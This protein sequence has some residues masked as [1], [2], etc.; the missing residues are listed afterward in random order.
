MKNEVEN[1]GANPG[2]VRGSVVPKD[3]RATFRQGVGGSR[4]GPLSRWAQPQFSEGKI[5]VGRIRELGVLRCVTGSIHRWASVG[6]VGWVSFCGCEG[7][8]TSP[9]RGEA[10]NGSGGSTSSEPG[11]DGTDGFGLTETTVSTSQSSEP[12]AGNGATPVTSHE[13]SGGHD[14]P[15][16]SGDEPASQSEST[17]TPVSVSSTS[18]STAPDE[19]A[20][21]VP[22]ATS[23]SGSVPLDADTSDDG[24][25]GHDYILCESFENA[26]NGEI[27]AGWERRGDEVFVSDESVHRGSKALK[28]D[29]KVSWERRIVHDASGLGAAHWGRI[30]YRVEL[31]VPDA[32]VH[33]TMVSATGVG[34]LNG[35]SEYR[36]VDTVKQAVDTRDVG[37]RHNWLFNVQPE[38][39]GEWA[40]ETSYDWEF[41][42]QWHCVEYFVDSVNQGFRFYFDGEEE[43][44][45]EDGAGHYDR[46]DLP[47]AF[48][49]LRVGWTNYQ[50]APPGFVAYIDDIAF[51]DVRIG[52]E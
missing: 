16:T 26:E 25:A 28:L 24:C 36:F 39:A 6:I 2:V 35:A 44:S 46:T 15:D 13:P 21:D 12:E 14:E 52:C 23:S 5:A 8:A 31:P 41:D 4:Q 38:E 29:R 27:P 10:S 50:D 7:A 43:L 49:E 18:L 9:D 40:R 30:Y 1:E 42:G 19:T 22:G 32:F 3:L 51:D 11:G 34:P 33:S 48:D 20:S 37:S 45:F 47:E 17:S